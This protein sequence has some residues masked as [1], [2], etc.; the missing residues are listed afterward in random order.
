METLPLQE[1]LAAISA[2][3][4][5]VGLH[6]A[7]LF[8]LV[9]LGHCGTLFEYTTDFG[10]DPHYVRLSTLAGVRYR[11]VGGLNKTAPRSAVNAARAGAEVKDAMA[12]FRE[13]SAAMLAG[14]R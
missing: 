5:L 2:S 1:Q 11:S 10:K 7:A 4:M 12:F 8:W 13:C 3:Q 14:S 6:G 9:V